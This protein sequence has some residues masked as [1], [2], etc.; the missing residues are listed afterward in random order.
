MNTGDAAKRCFLPLPMSFAAPYAL[1]SFARERPRVAPLVPAVARAL[2][3]MDLLARR[4][5]PMNM[6]GVADALALPRSSVHGLCNT[7]LSFGYLRRSDNGS[8]QI[9]PGVMSLADAF[10]ASTNVAAEFDALWRDAASAPDE[11]LILSVLNGAEVVYVGVRNS[12]RPLG[13]AFNVG[14]RMPANLAATGKAML[15]H[16]EPAEV[17]RCSAGAAA[18]PDG[19][20]R[21]RDRRARGRAGADARARLHRRRRRRAR[22][23]LQHRRA[24]PRRHRPGR[25][26]GRRL[27][28]QGRARRCPARAPAAGGAAGARALSRAAGRTRGLGGG[29]MSGGDFILETRA[30]DQGVQ[31]LRRRQ[32]RQ[33]ARAPRH[34]PRAD[35]PQRRRQDDLL[36]PADQV[37]D[38]DARARS[39][40]T[41]T[42]SRATR[43][44]RSR[45]AASI[46]SFQISAVFPHLTVLEN[47]RVALQRTLGT[48]FHFWRSEALAATSS[49]PA[50]MELLDE[51]DLRRVRRASPR[52]SCATAASARSRSP[53]RWRWT[54]S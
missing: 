42:T 1:P 30:A 21:G 53:P 2:A 25:G 14:M 8:L 38:A 15:A 3:V 18:A 50:R 13:L 26:R 32:Q 47:V 19:A 10:V 52:S 43:R 44:R 27:H 51:V 9:G 41:A 54:R 29:P 45:A 24:D 20:R 12:A 35:R 37:P 36:Q 11:T 6:A 49:T 5:E 28:Q 7:L 31:G 22:R 23:R 16:R 40:S 17:R 48:S 34:D 4:R 46:R 33:P 39:S